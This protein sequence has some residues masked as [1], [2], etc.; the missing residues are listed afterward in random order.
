M[1]SEQISKNIQQLLQNFSAKEF[2]FDLLL[3]YGTPKATVT[4]LKKGRHNLSKQEHQ[5]ILKKKLFFEEVSQR[6][7]HAVISD[8]QNDKNTMRHN[9][10]FIIITDYQTVLAVDTKTKEQLDIEITDLA[11]HYDFFLPWAGIEKHKHQNENPA[12][13]KAAE[14]MAKLYDDILEINHISTETNIHDLNI[15]LARL[16][17]CFFAED[18]GIFAD[19]IFTKGIASHT[20]TDGSD[21]HNYLD[22]LFEILDQTKANRNP[23]ITHYLNQFPYVNGKLFRN[24][25]WIPKFSAK[26]RKTIIE[27]GDLD[28]K[29]INPDIFGSMIQAVVH[30]GQRGSLGMHYT[31]VPNIMKVI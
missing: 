3:A 2:I 26:A 30:P 11:K 8:L 12:D 25:H 7:L 6:D 16:L 21:L 27:C 22:C 9:P 31:S 24:R 4:L 10:R 14:K 5:I 1:N 23:Q 19:G 15:F 29:E 18:T 17:F 20:Q 28:W 13:R